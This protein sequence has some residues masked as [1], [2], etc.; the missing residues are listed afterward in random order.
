MHV[1]MP[2]DIEMLPPGSLIPYANNAKQHPAQ[3]IAT[4]AGFIREYGWTVPILIDAEDGVIA[5][6]G[7]L[8]A[9]FLL[10]LELVPCIRVAHLSEPQV[11][12]LVIAD[13]RLGMMAGWDEDML[14]AEL[15]RL[16]GEGIDAIKLGFSE[17]E[18]AKLMIN[19]DEAPLPDLPNGDKIPYQQMTFTLHD[20]QAEAVREAMA[21]ADG[22]G[23]YVD[24][25]NANSNG[26]ALAR[27]AELFVAEYGKR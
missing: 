27:V 15:S 4:L 1:I 2:Q 9:A 18:L 17:E 8:E 3:Q 26:N 19:G 11:R 21:L 20:E 23:P 22:L 13:N 16:N 12:A 10:K 24:T 5:G 14:S 7:R 25:E 6:H